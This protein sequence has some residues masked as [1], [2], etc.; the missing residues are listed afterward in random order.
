MIPKGGG[1]PPHLPGSWRPL[2]L[3]PCIGKILERVVTNRLQE[4]VIHCNL[5]PRTQYGMTKRSTTTAL[6]FLLNPVYAAWSTAP[7]K[8]VSILSIDIKGAYD[9][10]GR[11]KLLEILIDFSIP[12]LSGLTS[13]RYWINIGIPQGSPLSPILFLFYTAPL[14]RMVSEQAWKFEVPNWLSFEVCSRGDSQMGV[15][16]STGKCHLMHFKPPWSRDPDCRL[17]VNIEGFD[18]KNLPVDELKILGVIVDRRL[19]WTAHIAEIQAKVERQLAILARFSSSVWGTPLV[20][21]VKLYTTKIRTTITYACPAWFIYGDYENHDLLKK[22][23]YKCL[24]RISGALRDTCARVIEKEL[25]IDNIEVTLTRHALT[26]RAKTPDTPRFRALKKGHEFNNCI[27]S[28]GPP[29]TRCRDR[30]DEC[31]FPP[32]GTS[33]IFRRSRLERHRDEVGAGAGN[34]ADSEL[35]RAG[36]LATTDPFGFLTDEVKN[37]YLRCSYKWSFHH[38]PNLLIAIRERRLDPLLVWAMLAITVRFSQAAPPGYA[39]QVEA[40]NTFAA[41]ARSLVLSLVDQ[42]TVHRAQVLLMLTGHSWGAGEGRRAWVYLGMAVRMAQVLGLFEEPPP[43]TTREDFIDAEERRRTAWTCFL[44]DSLLSGGK[45][46]DRMLSGDKMRIQLPCESDSFNFGQIVLCERLD[47]SMPDGAMGTVHGSLGIVA[48]SM[49]VADVWGAVAKWACT[50]HD[51]TVPPWQPQ[52][53]FQMLLSRL[54]L[55]KNSLPERLRYELFLLRAHSVSNQGQAYCYMHCIYFM[56]VI[57]LYRS[58]LPEV[59]MQKA[60]VGDKDW[61]QWSK[62]S[63]KELEKVAEQV[64]DMLQEIRAFGLYFLRGLVPWIGFTIYTAVGTMLYFY[65]FPN[66]GDTAHQVEKRRE[67]IVE[68]LLFLK[69]MRQAWPMADTWREKIKA[70]QIFYSNIKTDG[71]LAVTPSE[72]REMRNA[73]IDYGALQ[74]DPVRQ[75][76]AES[77]DEQSATDGEN[78]QTSSNVDF[79]FIAP[80][81]I[82]LFDTDF[83]FGSNMY[84]TFADATQGFWE[85]FPGS[86]DITGDMVMEN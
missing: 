39:T 26:H 48:N 12:V 30:G 25:V 79:S 28:G 6:Q 81:D 70:M 24:M 52:S 77:T 33:F 46:R 57:F 71:D 4:L 76:D 64:C 14:L 56:S 43:A 13:K 74:P 85:S 50:R 55:W 66:P 19:R 86:M 7:K 18:T 82:D 29:C 41:H 21:L 83:A 80:A 1:K 69:D 58:Y 84:A 38:I 40:S 47:G 42:P 2:A 78:D 73:I 15:T 45:G 68:G 49:R 35:I 61:D 59:E 60:R 17:T 23:Q 37:S 36:N 16:F 65:H 11:E 27:H 51:N 5:L 72:R 32:K 22:L 9:G 34:R 8:Y 20:E 53:E 44:M 75:P 63:S 62:W 67:H 10:V 3:L 54:E 31:V